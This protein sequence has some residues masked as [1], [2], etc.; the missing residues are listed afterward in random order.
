VGFALVVALQRK[1][2][3]VPSLVRPQRPALLARV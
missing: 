3:Y 1:L 2:V